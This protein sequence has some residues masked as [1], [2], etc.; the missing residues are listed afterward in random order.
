MSEFT[1]LNTRPVSTPAATSSGT[2]NS[3]TIPDVA[4]PDSSTD[5]RSRSTTNIWNS[6]SQRELAINL[7]SGK[8][9]ADQCATTAPAS[10]WTFTPPTSSPRSSP[11][12]PGSR[13]QPSSARPPCRAE[14]V[15]SRNV[16]H[17][18]DHEPPIWSPCGCLFCALIERRIGI[19]GASGGLAE[20]PFG[21]RD[22]DGDPALRPPLISVP[23][24]LDASDHGG[25]RN[26]G[27]QHLL[28]GPRCSGR[29]SAGQEEDRSDHQEDHGEDRER[30]DEAVAILTE[31][32]RAHPE[33][34]AEA[35]EDPA[36]P[37]EPAHEPTCSCVN[38][39]PSQRSAQ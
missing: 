19:L 3:G 1:V 26:A 25:A 32:E 7:L 15:K 20:R 30:H 4:T 6:S 12:Q 11:A 9:G 10:P 23:H 22:V 28:A 38:W 24:L 39:S 16:H 13:H 5:P 17:V 35:Y 31:H 29:G 37:S 8:S 18:N 33:A 2:S 21:Q 36:E 27:G 14:A 34:G